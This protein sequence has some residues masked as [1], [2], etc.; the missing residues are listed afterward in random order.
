MINV[1]WNRSNNLGLQQ[2]FLFFIFWISVNFISTK[3]E[4]EGYKESSQEVELTQ[5]TPTKS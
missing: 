5:L 1:K 2:S 4:K 3:K